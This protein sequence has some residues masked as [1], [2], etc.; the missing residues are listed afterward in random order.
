VDAKPALVRPRLA[1][2][3]ETYVAL[4]TTRLSIKLS[5]AFNQLNENFYSDDLR[6]MIGLTPKDGKLNRTETRALLNTR[7]EELAARIPHQPI[8]LQR[9]VAML[10]EL[11]GFDEAQREII[12][13]VAI[14][15]E[16]PCLSDFMENIRMGSLEA[17]CKTLA[18]ALCRR[19]LEIKRALRSDGNLLGTRVLSVGRAANGIGSMLNMPVPLQNALLSAADD[20]NQLMAAFLEVAPKAKLAGDAF[21]HL[22][23]ETALLSA[24]LSRA[25]ADKVIGVNVLLYGPP[26]CGKTEYVRYLASKLGKRLFQVRASDD[27]GRPVSGLNR[28]GFFLIAQ[29]FLRKNDALILVD[30]I[31]DIFPENQHG[32]DFD[33][34][35]RRAPAGKMFIN[36][37]L[38]SNPVP[39]IWVSNIV[40]HMDKAYLRR[41]DYSYAM[42]MPPPSVR[43]T[44]LRKYLGRLNIPD[45]TLNRLAQR[46]QLSPAQIEKAAKVLRVSGQRKNQEAILLQ[47]IDNS[48][49]LLEQ[50][51]SESQLDFSACRYR[52]DYLNADVD[53]QPLV[54]K[55]RKSRDAAGA[56]CLYGVPGSGKTA[57]AHYISHEIEMPIV[58]KRASDILSPYVGESEQNIAKIFRQ[59]KQEQAILLLD[60]A[61]SFLSDRKSA[62]A[63]WEVSAVNEMLTQMESHQGLF[64]CSTNL[65]QRLDEASLR[66]FALKIKFDYMRPEQRWRLFVEHV[67]KFRVNE[68]AMLRS[69]LDQLHNLTPGDFA[70]VRRQ[71]QLLGSKLAAQDWLE[72]LRN[73]SRAKRD[74]G[75]RPIGFIHSR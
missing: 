61:D 51:N 68:Q 24:Y 44:I 21:P 66:R 31:E 33:D 7:V 39:A 63:T 49:E 20:L 29:R 13:F 74:G 47:V 2:D 35:T 54:D 57:L 15:Q 71:V 19:E 58:A 14:M 43:R 53:L 34:A 23:D 62:R 69:A 46:E 32:Y 17:I 25:C 11:L 28:L 3:I 56:I 1:N 6:V 40:E 73:E 26:G 60:E 10:G 37:V 50:D 9:N 55:L 48:M 64:I 75:S 22:C 36:M 38:E 27:Q 5:A 41:F 59:A 42:S 72:R 16:H 45:A 4:W 65:M 12:T 8:R 70:T 30:E 18:A 52:L 67:K